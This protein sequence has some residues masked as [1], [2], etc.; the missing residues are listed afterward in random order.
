MIPINKVG[1]DN[2]LSKNA[3]YYIATTLPGSN[4]RFIQYVVKAKAIS[5]KMNLS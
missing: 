5:H 2:N 4:V 3:S 1:V